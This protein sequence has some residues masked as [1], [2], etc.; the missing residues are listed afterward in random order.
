MQRTLQCRIGKSCCPKCSEPRWLNGVDE[1]AKTFWYL[2]VKYWVK[3]LWR[4]KGLGRHLAN[5]L[6]GRPGSVRASRGYRRKVSDNPDMNYDHRNIG[7]VATAD[8]I[9]CHKDKNARSVVPCMLRTVMDEELGLNLK[10]CHLFALIPN[11]YSVYCPHT[12]KKIRKKRKTSFLTAAT[13]VLAD[14]LQWLY[15]DG[16]PCIDESSH[17]DSAGRHFNA[18]LI[19]L[20]WY[21]L[22]CCLAELQFCLPTIE[23]SNLILHYHYR[24]GDYPGLAE[25][26]GTMEAGRKSCRWCNSSF[27]KCWAVNRMMF[28]NFRQFLPLEDPMRH[29]GVYGEAETRDPPTPRTHEEMVADA[30]ESEA[31]KGGDANANHPRFRTGVHKMCPLALLPFWDM[32]WDFMPDWMHITKG[33]FHGHMLPLMKGNRP[34]AAATQLPNPTNDKGITQ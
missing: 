5:D 6:P 12:G 29:A 34:I 3:D 2:P 24:I 4:Q 11:W 14:E 20:Y 25:A 28:A 19:L 21:E 16:T 32:V 26:S 30:I 33:Y 13:T 8:G 9:P 18:K 17:P 15:S 1:P 31:F 22:Q 7:V 10:F 23:C 27:I